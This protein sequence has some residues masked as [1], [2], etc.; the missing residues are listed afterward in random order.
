MLLEVI[1]NFA[2]ICV[3]LP[4]PEIPSQAIKKEVMFILYCFFEIS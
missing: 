3:T 1:W 2:F 4:H